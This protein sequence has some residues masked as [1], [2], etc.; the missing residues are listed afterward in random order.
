VIQPFSNSAVY[1]FRNRRLPS[2][3]SSSYEYEYAEYDDAEALQEPEDQRF[4]RRP[5]VYVEDE[6]DL[7]Y[8]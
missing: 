8:R 7:R 4:K 6:V 3:A 5:E 2:D 1:V